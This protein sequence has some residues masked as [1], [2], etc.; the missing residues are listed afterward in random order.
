MR[1]VDDILRSLKEHAV[2]A[3]GR[4]Y[5][6]YSHFPVGAAVMGAA[7]SVYVGCNV[8][9]A[10]FGLTQCAERAAMTAA[11]ANGEAPGSLQSLVLY[12]PGGTAH[13]PCGACRQVMLELM[14]PDSRVI[15]C[16]GADEVRVWKPEDYL[17]D[18]FSAQTLLNRGSSRR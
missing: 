16:C 14:A 3:A 13:A 18:P 4:S 7:G 15:S 5:S 17:P 8:E 2:R 9:N 11:V 12:T 6:P 1:R 10:S